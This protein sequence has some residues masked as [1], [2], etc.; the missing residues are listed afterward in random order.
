MKYPS[1]PDSS[2]SRESLRGSKSSIGCASSYG[3]SLS[4]DLHNCDSLSV[5]SLL[6]TETSESHSLNPSYT[7]VSVRFESDDAQNHE[8]FQ[9]GDDAYSSA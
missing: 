6:S 4:K 2:R 5:G 3:S 8:S 7:G 1:S 9:S